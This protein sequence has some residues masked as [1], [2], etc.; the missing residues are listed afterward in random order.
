LFVGPASYCCRS[1]AQWVELVE[2]EHTVQEIVEGM[3]AAA[4]LGSRSGS[5][6]SF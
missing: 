5:V 2:G 3:L 6:D 1:D 4:E